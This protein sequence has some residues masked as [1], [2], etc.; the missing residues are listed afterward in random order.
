MVQKA[1]RLSWLETVDRWGAQRCGE[2]STSRL[3]GRKACLWVKAYI[4]EGEPFGATWVVAHSGMIERLRLFVSSTTAYISLRTRF[5]KRT[6]RTSVTSTFIEKVPTV[7]GRFHSRHSQGSSS[8][9]LLS[10]KSSSRAS[11]TMYWHS[12]LIPPS[13]PFAS[14]TQYPSSGLR[15]QTF[16]PHSHFC[17]C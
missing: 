13:A 4:S 12:H 17:R 3:S 6:S 8:I 5:A 7:V 11:H 15:W 2:E 9:S 1:A 14:I 10:F 16:R